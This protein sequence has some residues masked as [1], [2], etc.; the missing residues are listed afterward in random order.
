MTRFDFRTF[1][2]GPL[3]GGSVYYFGQ[4]FPGQLEALVGE[5]QK[6]DASEETHL[7][8]SI[9]FAAMFG[10][11]MMCQNREFDLALSVPCPRN[12]KTLAARVHPRSERFF[13][14]SLGFL[15]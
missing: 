1:N 3:Y 7:M 10:P 11:Q 5:L 8:I 14:C 13:S 2:Q 4:S 12:L 15:F 6:P 9:G